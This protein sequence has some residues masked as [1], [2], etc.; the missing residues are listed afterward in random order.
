MEA[1]SR[2]AAPAAPQ[3]AAQRDGAGERCAARHT[4]E[5]RRAME[6]GLRRPLLLPRKAQSEGDAGGEARGAAWQTCMGEERRGV[7]TIRRG[8]VR[9]SCAGQSKKAGLYR[10]AGKKTVKN[11]P[12]R[13]IACAGAPFG[14]RG[15][16]I[17][18]A[19]YPFLDFD[20]AIIITSPHRRQRN[21]DTNPQASA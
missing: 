21:I 10:H 17:Y 9:I 12:H 2:E 8:T 4:W 7:G 13:Q 6:T 14:T 15:R 16:S 20:S 11:D 3:G 1:G 18:Q 5:K 19:S